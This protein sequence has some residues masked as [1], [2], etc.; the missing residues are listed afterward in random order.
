M[1]ARAVVD[2]LPV[3]HARDE[4]GGHRVVE[5]EGRQ[6]TTIISIVPNVAVGALDGD[7]AGAAMLAPTC[8]PAAGALA[9]CFGERCQVNRVS[10]VSVRPSRGTTSKLSLAGS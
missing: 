4:A 8:D 10:G 9:S 7:G 3:I 5:R 2:E 6:L 1:K